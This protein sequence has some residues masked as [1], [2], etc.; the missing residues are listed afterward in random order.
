MDLTDLAARIAE[1]HGYFGG[2][3][4]LGLGL[5]GDQELMWYSDQV[6]PKIVEQV[7]ADLGALASQP[8]PEP[9]PE[10]ATDPEP[11]ADPEPAA[12]LNPSPDPE[13][14]PASEG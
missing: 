1:A 3:H 7:L 11:S 13:E 8:A 2:S 12:E 4:G 6:D 14:E 9:E 10:P 5:N